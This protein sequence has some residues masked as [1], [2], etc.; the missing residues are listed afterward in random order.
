M[1]K[2]T[3]ELSCYGASCYSD[4]VERSPS[5]QNVQGSIP[6]QI[7]SYRN[8]TL[9]MSVLHRKRHYLI[10]QTVDKLRSDSKYMEVIPVYAVKRSSE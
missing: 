3:L 10:R 7:G 5:D 4:V 8:V 9:Q 2:E 1:Y 6:D